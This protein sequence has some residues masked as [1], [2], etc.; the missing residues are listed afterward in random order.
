MNGWVERPARFLFYEGHVA[1]H[2]AFLAVAI[3]IA[4]IPVVGTHVCRFTIIGAIPAIFYVVGHKHLF[5][6]T[7]VDAE[8]PY[9]LEA[10]TYGPEDI[11]VPIAIWCET[12]GQE[13]C[14]LVD[15]AH[16]DGV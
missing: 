15:H 4:N 2:S 3:Y 7:V 9:G 5:S 1:L 12:G 13:E 6:V 11:V 14:G 16:V 8:E 10:Y